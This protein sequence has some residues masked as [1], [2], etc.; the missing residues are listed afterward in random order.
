MNAAAANVAIV[1]A[2]VI[3]FW[4]LQLLLRRAEPR[5]VREISRY[6]RSSLLLVLSFWLCV[7]C[8]LLMAAQGNRLRWLPGR[9]NAEYL[10]VILCCLAMMV[11]TGFSVVLRHEP[12]SQVPWAL[13]PFIHWAA[14]VV[15]V[16]VLLDTYFIW[17]PPGRVRIL[18]P[19]VA[20]TLMASGLSSLLICA[21]LL[22]QFR[23]SVFKKWSNR[24]R[25][26]QQRQMIDDKQK[27]SELATLRPRDHFEKIMSRSAASESRVV[28]ELAMSLIQQ[29][30]D[31]RYR[32]I[33]M[34]HQ[35]DP[36]IPLRFLVDNE[37]AQLN[38]FAEAVR[39]GVRRLIDDL[40]QHSLE[41]VSSCAKLATTDA[42]LLIDVAEA[43]DKAGI[44]F[45]SALQDYARV[46]D[47]V[48]LGKSGLVTR[49]M[50]ENWAHKRSMVIR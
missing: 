31:W 28:R 11:V 39:V 18:R 17:N 25:V 19:F 29:E 45:S 42:K 9:I 10:Q 32:V 35:N 1:L 30:P 46:I 26:Q 43:F 12:K 50:L 27:L 33:S 6:I 38:F 5:G 4:P 48:S 15:P 14:F 20:L 24:K 37:I 2:A 21:G 49:K 36:R 23:N 8:A 7:G 13:R 40:L 22:L 16:I 47:R 34:L 3:Y 44:D 41:G